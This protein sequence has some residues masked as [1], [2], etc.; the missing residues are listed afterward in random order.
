MAIAPL[1]APLAPNFTIAFNTIPVGNTTSGSLLL[2]PMH[3]Y[4]APGGGEVVVGNC[5]SIYEIVTG[6]W[7]YP[8]Q[9]GTLSPPMV[10]YFSYIDANQLVLTVYIPATNTTVEHQFAPD[11][12]KKPAKRTRG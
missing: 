1:K 5:S 12:A 7:Y 4:L 11:K 3:D 6:T 2:M 10:A 8:T 9:S